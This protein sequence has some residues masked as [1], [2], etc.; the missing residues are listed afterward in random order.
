M[1]KQ[2]NAADVYV[3][4]RIRMRRVLIGMSQE[5]LA[6]HLGITFQQVQKY[7]KGSNRV[8][9]SR[10]QAIS[11]V[12]GVPISFFFQQEAVALNLDGIERPAGGDEPSELLLSKQGIMLNQAF[13][14]ISDPKIRRSIVSLA[15]VLAAVDADLPSGIALESGRE[16]LRP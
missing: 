7:E 1:S 14:K 11:G 5:K 6:S 3:G 15:K 16:E 8:G 13:L 4:S 12:L 2:P 10:L 9:A